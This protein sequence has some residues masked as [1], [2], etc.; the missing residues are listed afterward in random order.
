MLLA[1]ALPGCIGEEPAGKPDEPKDPAV[2]FVRFSD[3]TNANGRLKVEIEVPKDAVSL[4]VTGA[5]AEYVGFEELIDPSGQTV[6][7]W[8]DWYNSEYSLTGAIYGTDKITALSWPPRDVDGPL[9]PGIWTAWIGVT[10]R[11]QFYKPGEVVDVSIAT[12]RDRDLSQ[13]RVGVQIVYARRVAR[14]A[15]VVEAVE[16]AVE[17]WRNIWANAGIVLDEYYT[18]SNLDPALGFFFLGAPEVEEVAQS[19]KEG[20][21]QLIIGERV[22]NEA[23]TLGVSAGIPGTVDVTERTFVVLSW[24][25]HAGPD[26]AFDQGE[27]RLMGETMAHEVGHYTGLF[28]PVEQNYSYWDALDDTLDC[29]NQRRCEDEL[30][31]NLMFP[32]SL[33]DF[34]SCTPQGKLSE[35]QKAVMQQYV[36]AL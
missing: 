31:T 20:D 7:Y 24:L 29:A 3:E 17:R 16:A 32:Y 25:A 8:E 28:H 33:C 13:A 18:E 9:V 22:G 27:T 26:G 2:T 4:Q 35:Q 23:Y 10:D 34:E 12:K 36:G 14:D 19:K 1:L 21:L 11:L 6:L 5:S 15:A 30:G